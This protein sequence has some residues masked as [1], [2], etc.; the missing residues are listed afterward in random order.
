ML[1]KGVLNGWIL[2]TEALLCRHGDAHVKD[3]HIS[4]IRIHKLVNRH[5]Y[6]D[7]VVFCCDLVPV[8]LT[9][10]LALL[11]FQ[12][13]NDCPSER[14]ATLTNI[15][16]WITVTND[17]KTTQLNT[18]NSCAYCFGCTVNGS[19][20][21]DCPGASD[22]TRKDM[23]KFGPYHVTINWEKALHVWRQRHLGQHWFR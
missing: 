1:V 4:M 7:F 2:H 12:W 18:I 19:L 8:E 15:G 16:R 6:I 10:I 21:H 14:E 13:E 23:D 5:L 22:V 20:I 11:Y 17:I 3:T 9:D